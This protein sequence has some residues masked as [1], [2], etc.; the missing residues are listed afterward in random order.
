MGD[1][2]QLVQ[3]LKTLA[4]VEENRQVIVGDKT[5]LQGLVGFLNSD[6][7]S[8]VESAVQVVQYLATN[9]SSRSPLASVSAC[10]HNHYEGSRPRTIAQTSAAS[11]GFHAT[12]PQTGTE[13]QL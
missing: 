12:M 4:S 13:Y 7:H 10:C 6:D 9:P 11:V 3:Q 8:V 1:S 5:C 2:R